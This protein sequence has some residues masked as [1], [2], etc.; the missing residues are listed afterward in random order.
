M[1]LKTQPW[2][3]RDWIENSPEKKDWWVLVNKKQDITQQCVLEP[4][5]QSWAALHH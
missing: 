4:G 3:Y 5:K 1:G 2:N